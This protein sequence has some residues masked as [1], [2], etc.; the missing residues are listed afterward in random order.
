MEV[1][2]VSGQQMDDVE[3]EPNEVV[4]GCSEHVSSLL[5]TVSPE[6][7]EDVTVDQT[8][9]TSILTPLLCQ[10]TAAFVALMQ[11]NTFNKLGAVR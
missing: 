2:F 7:M 4:D 11:L 6:T 5:T 3:I 10:K 9:L 8:Q 1:V